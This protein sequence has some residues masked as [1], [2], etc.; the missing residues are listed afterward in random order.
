MKVLSFSLCASYTVETIAGTAGDIGTTDATGTAA[1]FNNPYALKLDSAGNIY[2][3]DYGN[4]L[5]RKITANTYVVSTV[6]SAGVAVDSSGNVYSTKAGVV[7]TFAGGGGSGGIAAG[8]AYG[9]GT[10]AL[11]WNPSDIAVDSSGNLYVAD[12]SNNTIRKLYIAASGSETIYNATS[13]GTMSGST[14][15]TA[16]IQD[17]VTGVLPSTNTFTAVEVDNSHFLLCST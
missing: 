4:S 10:A 3:A 2:V 15:G 9:T 6:G 11:F 17:G 8:H 1:R 14:T 5:V 13:G 16:Y 12:C 7:T